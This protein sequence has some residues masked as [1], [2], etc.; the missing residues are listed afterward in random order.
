MA[1]TT[2]LSVLPV[3]SLHVHMKAIIDL[4]YPHNFYPQKIPVTYKLALDAM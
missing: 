1:T 2:I 4:S 3:C